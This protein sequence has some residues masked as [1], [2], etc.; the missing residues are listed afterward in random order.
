MQSF[1]E[2]LYLKD[3]PV[4]LPDPRTEEE[5]RYPELFRHRNRA[6]EEAVHAPRR[7]MAA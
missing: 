3:R 7:L 2:P 6:A 4:Q 1:R 5:I